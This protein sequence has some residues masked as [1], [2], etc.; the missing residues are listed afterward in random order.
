MAKIA[1]ASGTNDIV[2]TP[3]PNFRYPFQAAL[4]A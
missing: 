3:H 2:A 4:M 1:A